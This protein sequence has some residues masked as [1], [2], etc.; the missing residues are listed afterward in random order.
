[1]PKDLMV[2]VDFWFRLCDIAALNFALLPDPVN[3]N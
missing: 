1:M 3:S 2:A